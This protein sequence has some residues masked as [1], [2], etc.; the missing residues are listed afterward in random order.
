MYVRECIDV[1]GCVFGGPESASNLIKDAARLMFLT[2]SEPVHKHPKANQN[3]LTYYFRDEDTK[4]DIGIVHI[5]PS[6][7]WDKAIFDCWTSCNY[8]RNA[9]KRMEEIAK[10]LK[11][12]WYNYEIDTSVVPM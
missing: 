11:L 2:V 4:D 6:P 10:V 12:G 8:P 5:F 1:G 3:A 9:W 7:T